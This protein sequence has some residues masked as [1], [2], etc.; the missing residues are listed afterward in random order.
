M[1]GQA[2]ALLP[3][4]DACMR[5][6]GQV[7]AAIDLVA[8]TVGPGSFTGIRVGLA[9]ARGMALA[10]GAQLIGVTSFEAV[11]RPRRPVI[12]VQ[13]VAVSSSLSKA[14]GRIFTFSFSICGATRST[15]AVA[16]P[17]TSLRKAMEAAVGRTRRC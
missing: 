5:E 6:A 12:L 11:C 9:A 13:A 17:P 4:V 2:E 1:H 7:P 10:T 16:V 8:V 15:S 3:M 14:D